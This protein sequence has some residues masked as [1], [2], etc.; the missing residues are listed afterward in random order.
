MTRADIQFIRELHHKSGR[1]EHGL[2]IAEGEKLIGEI[3]SS[4]LVVRHIY[5]TSEIIFQGHNAEYIPLRD[6]ERISTLKSAN[7]SLAIVEIPRYTLALG[8]LEGSLTLALDEVQNPGNLGTIIRLA[9]W[10]GIRDII[11]ST[12]CAELYNPKTVQA[13]MGAIT[14]TRVHYT[15]LVPLLKECRMPIY[16]AVLGGDNIYTHPLSQ[17]GIIVMGNEGRGISPE[18]SEL[19]NERLYIPPYPTDNNNAESLNVAIS[20]AIICSEFRRR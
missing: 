12:N 19:L 6:M 10:F 7:N 2:F 14:R 17:S 16:G 4:E 15:P 5:T 3:L 11:C 9:D 20:T 13:T 1:R 8:E 18:L